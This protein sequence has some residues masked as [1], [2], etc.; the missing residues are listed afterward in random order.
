MQIETELWL[1]LGLNRFVEWTVDDEAGVAV[2]VLEKPVM[3]KEPQPKK[4]FLSAVAKL[5]GVSVDEQEE[6]IYFMRIGDNEALIITKGTP[7]ADE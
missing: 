6:R 2:L 3:E 1:H 5:L 4:A 7:A